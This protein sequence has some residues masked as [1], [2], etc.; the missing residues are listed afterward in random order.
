ME[1]GFYSKLLMPYCTVSGLGPLKI[2]LMIKTH[3]K[4]LN[5]KKLT[6]YANNLMTTAKEVNVS[7]WSYCNKRKG[8]K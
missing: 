8:L 7:P 3:K 4:Y 1:K 6:K 2:I 5:S